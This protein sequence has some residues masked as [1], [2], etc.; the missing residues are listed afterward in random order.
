MDVDGWELE[1]TSWAS[2]D[3]HVEITFFHRNGEIL[4][5]CISATKQQEI[6]SVRFKGTSLFG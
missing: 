2:V 4:F 3:I 5:L 6:L 1:R